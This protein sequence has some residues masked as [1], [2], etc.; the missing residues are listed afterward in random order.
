MK[1]AY[2]FLLFFLL[3]LSGCGRGEQ[4]EKKIS[5][6]SNQ[7][8]IDDSERCGTYTDHFFP[9]RWGIDDNAFSKILNEWILQHT[10]NGVITVCRFRLSP[11]GVKPEYNKEGQLI[12]VV[13]KFKQFG[14]HPE[15]DYSHEEIERIE[16]MYLDHNHKIAELLNYVNDSYGQP[17]DTDFNENSVDNYLESGTK[18]LA[19]WKTKETDIV[20]KFQTTTFPDLYGCKADLWIEFSKSYS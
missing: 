3:Y 12:R 10:T 18:T 20:V 2:C 14:V 11:D 15:A 17:T 19:G 8:Y 9:L 7:Q 5:P 6:L 13:M 16:E 1:Q 4:Q